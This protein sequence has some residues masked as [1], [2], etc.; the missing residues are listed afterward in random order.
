MLFFSLEEAVESIFTI[1]I[2]ANSET[3]KGESMKK[4][5]S[6]RSNQSPIQRKRRRRAVP[7]SSK[8]HQASPVSNG[9]NG[10][11]PTCPKCK[12]FLVVNHTALSPLLE[13][14]CINCGWQP[15]WGTRTIGIS[16]EMR[17]IRNRTS[18]MFF[19]PF[20]R[21]NLKSDNGSPR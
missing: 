14:R 10:S 7:S 20:L 5:T 8:L 3:K 18:Q 16:K 4:T 13:I 15:Q 21:S 19:E 12:G 1:G 2:V 9:K 17:S 11:T 6:R